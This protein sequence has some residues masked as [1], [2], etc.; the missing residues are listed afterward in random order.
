MPPM[1]GASGWMMSTAPASISRTCSATL[2]SISPVAIGVSRL[3]ASCGVALGVVGVQRL[4]D[5]DQV[6]LLEDAAHPLAVARSHCWLA[7]TISGTSSPRCSRTAVTRARS[8]F[9]S[10]WPTLS[11]MPPMPCVQRAGGVVHDLLDRGVQEAAGGVVGPHR[12]AVRAEQLGQRQAGALGLEVPQRDVERGDGLG[13]HAAAADRG[14]GPDQLGPE[15]ADVV[16]V[17]A[18]QHVGDLLGVRELGRAAGALGVAEAD[19]L[20]AVLGATSA[21]R[22]ATSVIGFCRR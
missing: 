4:L 20:V 19:A 18:D 21:N 12:V 11:L 13:G 8:S 7:S 9:Q 5:P 17:L 15:L 6:E 1:R 3:R 10:G 16:G 22:N 14:A 2:A